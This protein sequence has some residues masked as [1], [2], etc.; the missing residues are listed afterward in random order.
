MAGS[1]S[2]EPAALFPKIEEEVFRETQ[3]CLLSLAG[4]DHADLPGDILG[5]EVLALMSLMESKGWTMLELAAKS[6][7]A[8]SMISKILSLKSIPTTQ[9]LDKLVEALG[10][11]LAFF[12]ML[13]RLE[14]R[15]QVSR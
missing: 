6:K 13:A 10:A 15:S 2:S 9:V 3:A 1:G 5:G 11:D 4:A 14:V 12:F 8:R 7:V